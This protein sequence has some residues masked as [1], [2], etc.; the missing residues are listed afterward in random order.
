MAATAVI[1]FA[2]SKFPLRPVTVIVLPTAIACPLPTVNVAT[3]SA[4]NLFV[5][6]RVGVVIVAVPDDAVA[7]TFPRAVYVAVVAD[8]AVTVFVPSKLP[9]RPV[10]AMVFPTATP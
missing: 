6:V 9:P 4:I 3:L 2:P 5:G 7:S 1:V 8:T 10:T